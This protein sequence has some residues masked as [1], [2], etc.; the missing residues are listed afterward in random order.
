MVA[1][2]DL[3]DLQFDRLTRIGERVD[4][5]KNRLEKGK[6]I[7]KIDYSNGINASIYFPRRD[8]LLY[9]DETSGK[10]VRR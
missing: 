1:S 9:E 5:N 4:S 10:I 2:K 3:Q 8:R 6:K 7:M